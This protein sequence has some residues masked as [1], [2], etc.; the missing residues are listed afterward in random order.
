MSE[1]IPLAGGGTYR[2]TLAEM[3]A[4]AQAASQAAGNAFSCPECKTAQMVYYT[5]NLGDH[6]RR[7]Y[8]CRQCGHRLVTR[9]TPW[10][11]YAGQQPLAPEAEPLAAKP[12]NGNGHLRIAAQTRKAKPPYRRAA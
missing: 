2:V 8:L 7:V 12:Q 6:K 9:E 1:S 11:E 10:L 3:K 5:R 4:Q